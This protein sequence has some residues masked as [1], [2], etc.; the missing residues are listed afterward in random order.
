MSE[1]TDPEGRLPEL[2]RTIPFNRPCLEG[3]ELE[4]VRQAIE[5]G[6][7]SDDGPFTRQAAQLLQGV[8]QAAG[9]ILTTS[10]TD[11]LEMAALAIDI[12]PGDTVIVP[13][14]T[15]VSTA[16]AFVRAGARIRFADIEPQTLGV[17]PSHV[18]HLMD[19][20]VRAVVPVHYGGV[21]C[22][23]DG[24]QA[25]LRDSPGVNLVEDNAH[26]LF[27]TY[28]GSPLGSFGRFSTL[29]FHETKNV[30]CGEGGALVINDPADLE[31]ALVLRDKGTN[32]QVY[33]RG[34]V[35]KYSWTD[36]GSSFGLSDLLAAYL[37]GQLEQ[38]H[39][40]MRKRRAVFERYMEALQPSAD[41]LGFRLP[42]IPPDRTSA[43]HMF[44]VLLP[45]RE[46]RD[47]MLDQLRRERIHATFH[48]VPLHTSPAGERFG[49]A[50]SDCPV[51]IDISSRLIR[52]PFF[53]DLPLQDVDRIADLFLKVVRT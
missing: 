32:R 34:E 29:S 27:G 44:C 12:R 20:T 45:D 51:S 48:Y 50:R 10:C 26:G 7:A 11:A 40:I 52:L 8:H 35:D 38:R 19:E 14:F 1:P 53:N 39:R 16:L 24:L 15:F 30:S 4:Y 31:R 13:S 28:R 37:V 18:A 42:E 36:V 17:D 46:K 43:Y 21:A 49:A 25:V 47:H 22:D 23:L 41:D 3:R 5:S 6:H 2:E 9:V 33:I